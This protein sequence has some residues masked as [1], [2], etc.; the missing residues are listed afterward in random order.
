MRSVGFCVQVSKQIQSLLKMSACISTWIIHVDIHVDIHVGDINSTG[1]TWKSMWIS[2]CKMYVDFCIKS[3]RRSIWISMWIFHINLH[4][5]K[6]M[7]FLIN[8]LDLKTY[9]D[10]TKS[11][12]ILINPRKSQKIHMDSNKATYRLLTLYYFYL[13]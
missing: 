1:R 3:H 11:T 12:W 10:S 9:V 2:M 6:S 13:F 5:L 7:L 4:N 8:L